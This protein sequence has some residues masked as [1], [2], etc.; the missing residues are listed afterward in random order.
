MSCSLVITEAM[1]ENSLSLSLTSSLRI[2]VSNYNMRYG[3]LCERLVSTR[4]YGAISL[5]ED[6]CEFIRSIGLIFPYFFDYLGYLMVYSPL[7]KLVW[8]DM[9]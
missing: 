4:A 8:I 2:E 7:Y 6:P 9:P 1:R 3:V 5:P